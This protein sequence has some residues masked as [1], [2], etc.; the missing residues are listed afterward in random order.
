MI[1]FGSCLLLFLAVIGVSGLESQHKR[2][3]HGLKDLKTFIKHLH[4]EYDKP[5]STRVQVYT[6][7]VY[8]KKKEMEDQINSYEI[9]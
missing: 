1:R 6:D 4:E 8:R 7:E 2:R 9:E 3:D 5:I